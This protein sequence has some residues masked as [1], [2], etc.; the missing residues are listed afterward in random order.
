MGV[1][2]A[3]RLGG[4]VDHASGVDGDIVLVNLGDVHEAAEQP[5][6]RIY[7]HI[8]LSLWITATDR[9]WLFWILAWNHVP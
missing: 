1:G 2:G 4:F 7:V 5:R 6:D 9:V 3:R 8:R